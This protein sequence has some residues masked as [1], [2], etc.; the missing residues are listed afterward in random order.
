MEPHLQI[1]DDA[2][3]KCHLDFGNFILGEYIKEEHYSMCAEPGG[4]YLCHLTVKPS[5]RKNMTAA[6]QLAYEIH[7]PTSMIKRK[8][9]A[10][11]IVFPPILTISST[12]IEL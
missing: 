5:E 12:V 10:F 8:R 7:D 11:D 3:T 2:E 4:D 1:S 9:Q 6:E